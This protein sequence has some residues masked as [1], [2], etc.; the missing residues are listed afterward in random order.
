MANGQHG[1]GTNTILIVLL[2]IVVLGIGFLILW[3]GFGN[4]ETVVIP[5]NDGTQNG[6]TTEN[7]AG[8]DIDIS[9]TTTGE[10]GTTSGTTTE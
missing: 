8:I 4:D 1:G 2:I 10:N 6:T 9:G 7:G 3:N 5:E